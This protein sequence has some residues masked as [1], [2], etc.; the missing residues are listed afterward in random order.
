MADA[1]MAHQ[2]G[3]H[4]DALPTTDTDAPDH[5]KQ[6]ACE[7]CAICAATASYGVLTISQPPLLACSAQ[8]AVHASSRHYPTIISQPFHPPRLA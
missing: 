2:H 5:S 8:H 1:N 7:H 3:E 4:V 6:Q